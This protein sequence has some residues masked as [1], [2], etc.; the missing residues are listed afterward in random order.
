MS[1]SIGGMQQRDN[2][3]DY[4]ES[5]YIYLRKCTTILWDVLRVLI[6]LINFLYIFMQKKQ[7][8]FIF[9]Y[10]FFFIGVVF[11]VS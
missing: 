9:F 11:K 10:I 7:L 4:M 8:I 6:S 1:Q 3:L 2:V 5:S